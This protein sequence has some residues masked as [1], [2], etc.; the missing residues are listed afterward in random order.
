MSQSQGTCLWLKIAYIFLDAI[1]FLYDILKE[2][3]LQWLEEMWGFLPDGGGLTAC[4][5]PF[6]NS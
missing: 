1:C 4:K 2:N 3:T 6:A 5:K